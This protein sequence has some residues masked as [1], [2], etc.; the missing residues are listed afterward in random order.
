MILRPAEA[1]L[2]S[3]SIGWGTYAVGRSSHPLTQTSV[4]GSQELGT[5]LP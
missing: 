2:Q 3:C 1:S 5:I 4:S